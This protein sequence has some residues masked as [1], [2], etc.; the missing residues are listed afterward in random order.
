MKRSQ[1]VFLFI[2]FFFFTFEQVRSQSKKQSAKNFETIVQKLNVDAFTQLRFVSHTNKIIAASNNTVSFIDYRMG[3]LIKDVTAHKEYVQKVAVS[4]SGKLAFTVGAEN[5]IIFWSLDSLK[6]VFKTSLNENSKSVHFSCDFSS[7]DK[8]L[9]LLYLSPN[10]KKISH[11]NIIN[12]QNFEYQLQKIFNEEITSIKFQPNKYDIIL[13]FA[14][15][16]LAIFNPEHEQISDPFKIDNQ[17]VQIISNLSN[18]LTGVYT[19]NYLKEECKNGKLFIVDLQKK[20]KE[21]FYSYKALFMYESLIDAIDDYGLLKKYLEQNKE[22]VV[23]LLETKCGENIAGIVPPYSY[24]CDSQKHLI[25]NVGSKNIFINSS[26]DFKT[27]TIIEDYLT[28][29]DAIKTTKDYI[30][31]QEGYFSYSPYYPYSAWNYNN[32]QF[33]GILPIAKENYLQ[34]KT[35][36]DNPNIY[37][38]NYSELIKK[39]QFKLYGDTSM[40]LGLYRVN[41]EKLIRPELFLNR[42]ILNY[43]LNYNETLLTENEWDHTLLINVSGN[44]VIQ[45]FQFPKDFN[46]YNNIWPRNDT[47]VFYT[48]GTSTEGIRIFKNNI[49]DGKS[50]LY[51]SSDEH[52]YFFSHETAYNGNRYYAFKPDVISEKNG[53]HHH[54]IEVLDLTN[55]KMLFRLK[56]DKFFA[57]FGFISDTLIVCETDKIKYYRANDGQLLKEINIEDAWRFDLTPDKKYMVVL[58][59]AGYIDLLD[60]VSGNKI[61]SYINSKYENNVAVLPSGYYYTTKQGTKAIAFNHNNEIFPP[62]QMDL[63]FNRQDLVLKAL[64]N[65][66]TLLIHSFRNAYL[67]RLKKMHFTENMLSSDFHLPEI[68]IIDK[69]SIPDQTDKHSLTLKLAVIDD[70]FKIDRINILINDVPVYGINGIDV[71]GLKQDSLTKQIDLTLSSGN[72]KVQVSCLNE[73]GAESLKETFYIT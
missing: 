42:N 6:P 16:K 50:N 43:S 44:S 53:D 15:G 55:A 3:R 17:P 22:E 36:Y 20:S 58:K 12:T 13:G 62:E 60:P 41:L 27:K 34:L 23:F 56:T 73:K 72:N 21:L 64:G 67:K 28:H 2:T 37:F 30:I 11:L 4:H 45:N 40:S 19:D 33:K 66:D 14:N 52:S 47:T 48:V 1:F 63:K 68:K 71:R 9:A 24:A 5:D 38:S 18:G 26:E 32:L 29:I 57:G 70:T 39:S 46:V 51:F 35:S 31:Q 65:P 8:F 10:D 59:G 7:D 69:D 49:R 54:E 25:A 61:V